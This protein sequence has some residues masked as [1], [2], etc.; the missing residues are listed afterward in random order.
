MER[1]KPRKE[2]MLNKQDIL[3]IAKEEELQ[4]IR[5]WFTDILGQIKGFNLP[6]DDLQRVLDEGHGFDGSSVEGFVR[7]EE[8]DLLVMPDPRTFRILPWEHGGVKSGIIICDVVHPDGSPF[9]CDPRYV[10]R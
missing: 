6:I 10:L 5:L 2:K 8:S 7:I 3:K 1:R 9:D 4:V